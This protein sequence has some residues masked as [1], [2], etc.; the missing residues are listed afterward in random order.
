MLNVAVLKKL[1]VLCGLESM[2][3]EASRPIWSNMWISS[4]GR[5]LRHD[6]IWGD[7]WIGTDD[8]ICCHDQT[9][10]AMRMVKDVTRRFHEQFEVL[11]E[12]EPMIEGDAM[13]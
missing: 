3:H 2:W 4:D 7:R 9:G 8:K 11:C 13:T 5:G 10:S 12:L 1:N 6:L